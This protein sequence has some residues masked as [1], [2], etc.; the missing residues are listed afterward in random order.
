[1]TSGAGYFERAFG[2]LLAANVFKINKKVLRLAQQR[3]GVDFEGQNPVSGI[4]KADH[5]EK[6]L[7]RIDV[8]PS[9]HGRFAGI[10]FGNDNSGD[11]LGSGLDCDRQ[12][13]SD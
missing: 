6:R 7:D 11:F 2:R 8:D 10:E 12:G 9:D 5:V 13:A 1:V 4:H 3:F